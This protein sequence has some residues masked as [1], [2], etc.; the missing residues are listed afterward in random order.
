MGLQ[1]SSAN[2]ALAGI[3][4]VGPQGAAKDD[5]TS[6]ENSARVSHP[7]ATLYTISA[8]QVTAGTHVVFTVGRKSN[9]APGARDN[10]TAIHFDLALSADGS[11]LVG[12][13]WTEQK[14]WDCQLSRHH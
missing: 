13:C 3:L 12:Q 8:L 1:D 6:Y 7:Q 11:H 2:H 4:I 10:W 9:A 14:R 5:S